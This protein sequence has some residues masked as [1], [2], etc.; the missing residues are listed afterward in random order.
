M[1]SYLQQNDLVDEILNDM[2]ETT[3]MGNILFVPICRK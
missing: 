1:L 2:P 3:E